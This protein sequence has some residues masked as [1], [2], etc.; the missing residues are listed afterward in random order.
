MTELESALIN[1]AEVT[2][3]T[4]RRERDSQGFT[5]LRRD[6]NDAGEAGGEARAAVEVRLGRPVVSRENRQTLT[7]R[8]PR[9]FPG[10]DA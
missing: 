3:T 2:A 6:A 1:L 8:R 9:L 10:E 5:D 4:F 7:D